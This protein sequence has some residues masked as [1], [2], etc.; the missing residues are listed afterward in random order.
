MN[1]NFTTEELEEKK[2]PVGEESWENLTKDWDVSHQYGDDVD[3][4]EDYDELG[5]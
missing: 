5:Q 4:K 3:P 1:N 2:I